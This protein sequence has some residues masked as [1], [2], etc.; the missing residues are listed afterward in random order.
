MP[1]VIALASIVSN[2]LLT[3]GLS[4]TM[5]NTSTSLLSSQIWMK[6]T[7][8]ILLSEEKIYKA[9]SVC[10][11]KTSQGLIVYASLLLFLSKILKASTF[12]IPACRI[13]GKA[14]KPLKRLLG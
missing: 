10:E 1:G 13:P 9:M 12:R 3:G 8:R 7:L 5:D 2:K 4:L 14:R 6:N 11:E